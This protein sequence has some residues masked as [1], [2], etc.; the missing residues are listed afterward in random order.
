MKIICIR[1]LER[2]G[3]YKKKHTIHKNLMENQFY[4]LYD[5]YKIGE[6]YICRHD[7]TV[8]VDLYKPTRY[9]HG[10]TPAKFEVS[11]CAIVGENGA[12]KSTLIDIYIRIINNLAVYIF[13]E[14][15]A[16]PKAEH[17][18]FINGVFA[19]VYIDNDDSIY[20]IRS[21]ASTIEVIEFD[22]H[23]ETR[24][25][26]RKDKPLLRG[27]IDEKDPYGGHP[28]KKAL[29]KQLCYNTI[30]NYS[31]H[32]YNSNY[33]KEENTNGS[34]EVKIRAGQ[35]MKP[36]YF[37]LDGKP[38]RISKSL[39]LEHDPEA[40]SWLG[41]VFHKNDGFQSP[42]VITPK[43]TFGR[44][45]MNR[46]QKMAQERLLSLLF[47]NYKPDKD[48]TDKVFAFT[49]INKKLKIDGFKIKGNAKML[50]LYKEP[51]SSHDDLPN[52]NEDIYKDLDEFVRNEYVDTFGLDSMVRYHKEVA[53]NYLVS[54]TIKIFM[55]YPKYKKVREFLRKKDDRMINDN[56]RKFLEDRLI[57][58]WKDHSH[59]TTKLWRALNY[60][61]Y[62]HIGFK[63]SFTTRKMD[64]VIDEYIRGEKKCQIESSNNYPPK[65]TDEMLPPSFFDVD[66]HLYDVEDVRKERRIPFSTL[67]SGEKQV[68]YI[69]TSL[70]YY[71]ICIDSVGFYM[72]SDE[73]KKNLVEYNHI[74]VIFDEIELYFH[75]EMQRTFVS[76][77]LH[78]LQQLPL[79]RTKSLHFVIVTHSP[80]VLSDIPRQNILF[81]QKNGT[82]AAKDRKEA[83]GAN[84]HTMLQ[85]SFFLTGGTMGE[86]A[87]ET[88]KD[89]ADQL[90]LY[91]LWQSMHTIKNH[92]AIN[93]NPLI[94][95]SLPK[96]YREALDK[97]QSNIEKN[98]DWDF[99]VKMS[100]IIQEPII[101][102]RMKEMIRKRRN[103]KCGY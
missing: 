81:L 93:K 94:A 54:K 102:Q 36:D 34:K 92:D 24:R 26:E 79:A 15:F 21:K 17:L 84:I 16:F 67:S 48:N 6:N 4:Y 85:N 49:E 99:I 47:I 71:M 80:F 91:D 29:L 52:Y 27:V 46:E 53:I 64:N 98:I 45:D 44:M 72:H 75:P 62:D 55:T 59:V 28:E 31:I 96:N 5:G 30:I 1:L 20:C 13:G 60:L 65:K 68:T 41:G 35:E 39:I 101:S 58:L 100:E 2:K 88:I 103:D 61:R 86:F 87:K 77:L 82:P 9:A 43:R 40:F 3:T 50:D 25:F 51:F 23:S 19:E 32:S 66:F 90:N 95:A 97:M 78:G 57:V 42:I 56:D 76:T 38:I 63:T 73:D 12:G 33:Y 10:N 74:N 7:T 37:F 83:F 69:L 70:F 11:F 89:I 14:R 18:H 8:P 22:Y